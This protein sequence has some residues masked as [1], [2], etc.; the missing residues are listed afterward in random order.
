MK[1]ELNAQDFKIYNEKR[2]ISEYTKT[3]LQTRGSDQWCV[4]S[5]AGNYL[6]TIQ[7]LI[8]AYRWPIR[9]H[10]KSHFSQSELQVKTCNNHQARESVQLVQK[11][12]NRVTDDKRG[13][14]GIGHVKI[15]APHWIK[16]SL[17]ALIGQIEYV[18]YIW[19]PRQWTEQIYSS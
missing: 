13:K 10:T 15:S 17:C 9:T 19:T 5:Y 4:F 2:T 16:R 1:C 18:A 7:T 12:G 3:K 14:T 8:S 11:A 6:M